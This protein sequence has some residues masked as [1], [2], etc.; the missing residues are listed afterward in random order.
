[1]LGGSWCGGGNQS[2]LLIKFDAEQR[3]IS[4]TTQKPILVKPLRLTSGRFRMLA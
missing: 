2:V 4:S 3:H 1:M